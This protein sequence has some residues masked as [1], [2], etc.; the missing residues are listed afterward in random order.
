MTVPVGG[1]VTAVEDVTVA[2]NVTGA[3]GATGFDEVPSAVAVPDLLTACPPDNCPL[4]ALKF[5]SPL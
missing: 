2:V 5:V 4:V 3:L 1:P